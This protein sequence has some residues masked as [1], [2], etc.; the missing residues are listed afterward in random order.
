MVM[1]LS[2]LNIDVESRFCEDLQPSRWYQPLFSP[3]FMI[4]RM[5]DNPTF[6]TGG[7]TSIRSPFAPLPRAGS[8]TCLVIPR[9]PGTG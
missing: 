3:P 7:K 8:I 9:R 6:I 2:V 1:T 4:D 5:A